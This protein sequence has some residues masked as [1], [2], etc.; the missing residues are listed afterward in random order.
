MSASLAARCFRVTGG[1]AAA[2][3]AAAGVAGWGADLACGF[4]AGLGVADVAGMGGVL[5]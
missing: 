5:S 3:V 1:A 2:L 4:A